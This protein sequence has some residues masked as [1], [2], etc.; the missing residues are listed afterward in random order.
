MLDIKVDDNGVILL[1]GRFD[2]SQA[3]KAETFMAAV[4]DSRVCDL[5]DLH[6][7]S[8]LGLGVR[9][10]TQKRLMGRG[11]TLK[12]VNV[13]GHVREVF[14]YAGFDGIFGIDPLPG[15]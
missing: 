7:L 3:A 15:K 6:Y 12:L 11:Q 2:A 10:A 1:S 5:G 9:L 13:K 4:T 8:S 14:H